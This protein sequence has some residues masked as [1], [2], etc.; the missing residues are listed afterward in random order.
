MG[1][2][3]MRC[4]KCSAENTVGRKFCRECGSLIVSYCRNCGFDNSLSD[5]YCGGCGINLSEMHILEKQGSSQAQTTE[6]PSG[7]YSADDISELLHGK[8]EEKEKK[9]K[10]EEIKDTEPVSQDFLDSMFN[11]SESD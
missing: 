11:S 2:E 5:K 1:S 7:K 10:K 9:Q 4:Q 8:S 3:L 6:K